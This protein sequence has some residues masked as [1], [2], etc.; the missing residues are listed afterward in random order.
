MLNVQTLPG[1]FFECVCLI[2][3]GFL[4]SGRDGSAGTKLTRSPSDFAHVYP[5]IR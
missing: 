4:S 1:F 3:D 2:F 5:G